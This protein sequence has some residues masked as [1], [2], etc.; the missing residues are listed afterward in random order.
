MKGYARG[1]RVTVYLSQTDHTHQ[2]ANYMRIVDYLRREG[3]AGATVVRGFAGFGASSRVSTA[4]LVDIAQHLPAIVIWIDAPERVERLLPGVRE[5]AGTGLVVLDEVQIVAYGRRGVDQ[6]RFDLHVEDVMRTEVVSVRDDAPLRDAVD[7]LVGQ[8]FR[9]LPVVDAA[10]RLR[11]ILSN[12]DLLATGGLTARLE[13]LSAMPA[14]ERDGVMDALADKKVSEVMH[15]DVTVLELRDTMETATRR[16]S[17]LRLKRLPVVD[18]A[19]RLAGILSRAD[20]LRAV[21]ES[22]PRDAADGPHPGA[23]TAG[24]LM[25]ADAPVVVADAPLAEVV[26]VVASTR[27][28]RAVVVDADRRVVG[29]V[30]DADVL[31]SVGAGARSGVVGA[32]M[33]VGGRAHSS[34]TAADVMRGDAPTVTADTSL[35]DAARMIVARRHKLLPVVDA[36]RHLLGILDRADL[37]KAAST[38]LDALSR[39]DEGTDEED[40]DPAMG[41]AHESSG[42]DGEGLR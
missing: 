20:V 8:E 23:M 11:G 24:D 42:P 7:L 33:R 16:M 37:L 3:A 5:R 15:R 34:A 10:R 38:V 14:E 36:D 28:N 21:A 31:R 18:R 25:R 26:M 27:L 1:V 19:G 22:F 4:T 39:A 9:A 32:L 13:L 12:G 29:V 6:L 17:E 30:T 40:G 35:A 2:A 41:M